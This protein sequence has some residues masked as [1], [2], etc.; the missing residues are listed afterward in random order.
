MNSTPQHPN[1]FGAMK[2]P[3]NC[4]EQIYDG[5]TTKPDADI[6]GIGVIIAFTFSA[7]VT[8]ISVIVAYATGLVDDGL[9]RPMDRLVFRVPSR[10]EKHPTMH[11]ALRKFI[12][13]LSDQQIVTGIAILGAGFQG[14]RTGHVSVYHFQIIIYLAWMSSSVHLSALTILG[15]YLQHHRAVMAWRLVGMLTLL[16]MLFISLVPTL[17]V[18]WGILTPLPLSEWEPSEKTSFGAP[19]LCF[20]GSSRGDGVSPDA[21]ISFFILG[22]SY[23]WKVC[24]IFPSAN[25]AFAAWTWDPLDRLTKHGFATLASRIQRKGRRVDLWVFRMCLA[26]YLPVTA[27]IEALDSFSASLWLSLLGLIYG[28]LQILVPRALVQSYDSNLKENEKMLTFGQLVPLI[29]LIQPIG[30][31]TEHIWL[32]KEDDERV[33]SSNEETQHNFSRNC[34]PGLPLLQFLTTF[35]V[36]RASGA[37]KRRQLRSLLYSSKLFNLL[38]WLTQAGTISAA[39]VVFIS[40]YYTIGYTTAGNWY[41]ISFAIAGYLGASVVLVI[42]LAPFSCLGRYERRRREVELVSRSSTTIIEH[43]ELTK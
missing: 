15:T 43:T 5:V 41:Y 18:E 12:L 14:L 21:V 29:L 26:V 6:A 31:L 10:A 20:W 36:P 13:A 30:A 16:V 4:W 33:Y 17:S 28:M 1:S 2:Q 3:L 39:I 38:I 32:V 35:D 37:N 27:A 25:S 8:L 34:H 24:G 7:G 40:D 19:A 22:V 11:L 23:I 42:I 9:L